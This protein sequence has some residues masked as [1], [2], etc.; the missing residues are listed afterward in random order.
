MRFLQTLLKSVASGV[1]I[2][3]GASAYLMSDNKIVGALLFTVGLFTICFFGLNLYTGKIGYLLD[4]PRPY[5]CA[6]IWLGNVVGCVSSG[7]LLRYAI[8]SLAETAKR[9]TEAKLALPLPR[10]AVL[11]VFCGILMYVAVHNYIEN[12]HMLGKCVGIFVCIPAFI[13]C[14]FEHCIANVVYFTLGISSASQLLPMLAAI[15]T[16]TA[17]NA[18]GAV[19]F[20]K[21]SLAF[22]KNK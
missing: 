16:V 14:G 10:A 11:G 21:L 18:V 17:A 4:M 13:I 5:D 2:S 22:A 8:P 12:P 3:I 15:L 6:T 19:F 1:C 7:A 20:R 9:V